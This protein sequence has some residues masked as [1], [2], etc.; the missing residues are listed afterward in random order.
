MAAKDRT[1]VFEM[2]DLAD[3]VNDSHLTPAA[4]DRCP[5]RDIDRLT[6]ALDGAEDVYDAARELDCQPSD[7]VRWADV[8]DLDI[9]ALL[10]GG[11]A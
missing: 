8:Y 10:V 6:E 1:S 2:R 5:F 11:G 9:D 4:V 7:V 3:G